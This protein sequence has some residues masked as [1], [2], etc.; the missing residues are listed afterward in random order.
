MRQAPVARPV[1]L[2]RVT[3]TSGS[4][5][6]DLL[7]PGS[8][9]VAEL[10]PELARSVGLLDAGRAHGGFRLVTAAGRVLSPADALERQG[11]E[12]GA[13]LAVC[14]AADEAPS[15]V[16]DDVAEA[17]A[18]AVGTD[19]RLWPPEAGRRAGLGAATLSMVLGAIALLTLGDGLAAG[20]VGLAG[21]LLAAA[22][23]LSRIRHEREAAVALAWTSTA[24]A[25]AAGVLLAPGA[26]LGPPLAGA[27]AGAV[28]VGLLAIAGLESGRALMVPPV[29]V[30][31]VALGTGLLVEVT[32]VDEAVVL[33]TTLVVVVLAG[34]VLPWLALGA[35]GVGVEGEPRHAAEV[36]VQRVRADARAASELLV[37]TSA[38]LG[39]LMV[40]VLPSA[41]R[42]GVAGTALALVSC[43]LV[44]L[45]T[46]QHRTG[47][48]VRVGLGSGLAGLAVVTVA[49]LVRWPA[50][51][52]TTAGIL[53]VAGAVLFAATLLSVRWRVRR[54]R[55]GDLAETA[56]LV[57]LLP[58]L[59][60][61]SGLPSSLGR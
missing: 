30:G 23:L 56:G 36:D 12:D 26:L 29:T 37:A 31:V 35:T 40:L 22:V 49:V 11:V 47:A 39:L 55:L 8:V 27:G 60:L 6:V 50:W 18:E 54:R 24:Y 59:V 13:F 2:L 43:G 42:L 17:L 5:R 48:E 14:A 1:V 16:H 61:A 3:V 7:L 58:L 57:A 51:R 25:A 41:V 10:L 44:L 53:V 19:L 28:A 20:A 15:R 38:A 33:S 52:P 4:R 21:G 46:R 9:P 32:G 45:R 34:T